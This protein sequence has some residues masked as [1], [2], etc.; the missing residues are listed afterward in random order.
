MWNIQ[1]HFP[2]DF[3][4]CFIFRCQVKDYRTHD[5]IGHTCHWH[6]IF[7]LLVLCF[8][9]LHSLEIFAVLLYKPTHH[10]L[11][12]VMGSIDKNWY[13]LPKILITNFASLSSS[14]IS[15]YFNF[16]TSN[17]FKIFG[18]LQHLP[19]FGLFH[20]NFFLEAIFGHYSNDSTKYQYPNKVS[21][22]IDTKR[23]RYSIDTISHHHLIVYMFL[24]RVP[25]FLLHHEPYFLDS[26][27]NT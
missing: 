25:L 22:L 1:L 6:S 17:F 16:W 15:T 18:F 12:V 24:S 21:I 26:P 8:F 20:L 19:R 9:L 14:L 7:Q 23:Y 2:I 5:A 3:A 4:N 13:I 10:S 11:I 27:R